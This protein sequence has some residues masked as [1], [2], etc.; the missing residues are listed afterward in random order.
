MLGIIISAKKLDIQQGAFRVNTKDH[1]IIAK[2]KQNLARR[3]ARRGPE[4]GNEPV[5]HGGNY[6]YE[7]AE[8]TQALPFGGLGAVHQMARN[9]KL[10]RE[11]NRRVKLLKIHNPYFESDHV[12]NLAYNV[13]CGGSCIEDLELRRQN[14]EYMNALGAHSIPDPTTAG[15]FLRRFDEKNLIELMEAIND[16]REQVWKNQ[17]AAFFE[18]AVVDVDATIAPT[19]GEC[20]EGMDLSYK[21]IWG[22]APLIVSL[23]NTRE[24]LYLVNRP[25]NTPSSK[26]AAPWLD[27][28]IARLQKSGFQSILLRGDTDYSQTEH[29]DRWAAQ[30]VEFIFGFDACAK[31]VGLAQALPTD[32]WEPLARRPKYEVQTQERTRPENVKERIVRERGY[33]NIRLEGEDVAEFDYR[34]GKCKQ[35]YR[36]V[37]VRK[38]LS[39]ARG[40]QVLF[41]DVRYFFYITN[42]RSWEAREIVFSANQRCDQENLI[43]QLKSGINALRMPAG[44][45]LANWAYMVIAALAWSLKAWYALTIPEARAR[46]AAVRMEFKKFFNRYVLLPCQIVHGGRRLVCRVLAYSEHLGTFFATF[47]AIRRLHV[48]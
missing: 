4:A 25:G 21:G 27:R 47:A 15:D 35:S 26:D 31:L 29:L 38:N 19:Q 5:M 10:D 36:M 11:I 23:A 17:P 12:L 33:K 37:A 1:K 28:A 13:F 45:L 48:T 30:G 22:Y 8:R 3:L 34:P 16:T 20:K 41:D 2:G 40:E 9:L 18:R 24:P 43:G 14:L 44:D 32:A 46:Q 6:H 7:M 39:V 42:V